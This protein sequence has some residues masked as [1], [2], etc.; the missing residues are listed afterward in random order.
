MRLQVDKRRNEILEE[1]GRDANVSVNALAEK[2]DVTTETIRKDLRFWE[3]KGVLRKTHG[4]AVFSAEDTVRHISKRLVENVDAK[5]LLAEKALEYIPER[6][7]IFLDSGS[8]MLCLAK[9]VSILSGLTIVTN[10]IIIANTLSESKNTVLLAGGRVWGE[11]LGTVGLWATSALASIR[12]DVAFIGCSGIIGFDGPTVEGLADAEVKRT[13]LSRARLSV[14]L[15]DSEKFKTSGLI[16][17]CTW[18]DIG[19]L[20]TNA[21]ADPAV[22]AEIGEHT[23]VVKV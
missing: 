16:S 6:G 3:E 15:A 1:L 13:V 11:T 22:C 17:F 4:G 20:I 12:L 9:R 14:A 23:E 5:N 18:K 10:S 2:F 19:L 7:V 21:D 8:T